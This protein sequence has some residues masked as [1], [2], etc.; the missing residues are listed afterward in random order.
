MVANS[1]RILVAVLVTSAMIK[2]GLFGVQRYETR[3]T[4]GTGW[5]NW[6]LSIAV[7]EKECSYPCL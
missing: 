7:L 5:H 4:R 3:E 6:G 2:M 1:P